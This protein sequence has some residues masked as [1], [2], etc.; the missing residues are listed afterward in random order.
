MKTSVVSKEYLDL[1][2]EMI[3]LQEQ[4]KSQLNPGIIKA[5][6]DKAA[7][8][9]GV[10]VLATAAIDFDITLFLQWIEEIK[11]LLLKYNN[12]LAGKLNGLDGLLH[13]ETARSWIDGALSFND[14][15]FTGFANQHKIEDWI[16][17]FLAQS[18]VKPYLLLLAEA[19]QSEITF[20]AANGG[21]P[22]CGEPVRLAQLE[23]E[24]Q[25]VLHCPRCLVHWHD[26]RLTCSHCGNDDHTTIKFLTIEG[27]PT[28]QIQ[29]CEECKGYTKIIDTRQL[30]AKPSPAVL[31]LTTIHLDYVA[32]EQGYSATGQQKR[33][34]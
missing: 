7:M 9:A 22:V 30:I 17:Q 28:S 31:D 10:P 24:G 23:G 26:K 6:V 8:D 18:A 13:E 21:C 32:Q 29:A 19:V 2:K 3:S 15:Y 33:V 16:P 4:W 27:E 20:S 12:S 11:E 5:V 1:H 34:N 14:V 25:K